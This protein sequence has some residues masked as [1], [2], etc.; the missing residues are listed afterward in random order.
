[1][2]LGIWRWSQCSTSRSLDLLYTCLS[3]VLLSSSPG[4]KS[5]LLYALR[6]SAARGKTSHCSLRGKCWSLLSTCSLWTNSLST[7][8]SGCPP[9]SGIETPHDS[10]ICSVQ[11]LKY[12]VHLVP[13]FSSAWGI[14]SAPRKLLRKSAAA[15]KAT[16]FALTFSSKTSGEYARMQSI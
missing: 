11:T 15:S 5:F 9:V 6:C 13:N 7:A 2:N 14:I 12:N 10:G 16:S 1:M 4:M 8:S 3:P